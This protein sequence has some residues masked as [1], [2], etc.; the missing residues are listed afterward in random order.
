MPDRDVFSARIVK[1]LSEVEELR[2]MWE[3]FQW[4][5]DTDIDFFLT[6]LKSRPEI[7]GPHIVVIYEN[8]SPI[9]MAVGRIEE[10]V[11]KSKAGYLDLHKAKVR[12]ITFGYG[13]L[14]GSL[15]ESATNYLWSVLLNCLRQNQ[16]EL[17]FFNSLPMDSQMYLIS[18]K[19]TSSLF[20]DHFVKPSVH[21]RMVVPPTI[22]QF[23]ERMRSKH[24]SWLR[25]LQK[26]LEKEY[27][28]QVR[29]E[30]IRYPEHIDQVCRDAEE[31]AKKTY[32]RALG[33]G[34][35]DSPASRKLLTHSA[36]RGW[37]RAHFLYVKNR[38]CAFWIGR[39]YKNIFYLD[40]TSYDPELKKHELGTQLLMK[41]IEDSCNEGTKSIDFGLG[42]A[43][44]KQR[45]GDQS[46][47]E[48][49]LLVFAPT[50]SGASLNLLLTLTNGIS[51]VMEK[52]LLKLRL[53][54][55]LKTKWRKKLRT[56]S[57]P[58]E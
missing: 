46:W 12:S 49:E 8:G 32:Q 41:V 48:S 57:E 25:R 13:G 19:R 53:R 34:F 3:R 2:D 27:P 51:L 11:L 29:F 7:I 6:L 28:G 31:V 18:R 1:T 30:R 4:Y 45:F 54:D 14:I 52:A 23:L 9:A 58:S 36:A 17:I 42:D 21:W 38:P 15:N 40:A 37:L 35:Q 50:L 44:Y 5:P 33:V 20:R 26:G 22:N 55:R 56:K 47:L 16:S 24:R 43:F 39:V 10:M